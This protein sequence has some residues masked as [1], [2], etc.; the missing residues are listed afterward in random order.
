MTTDRGRGS[1]DWRGAGVAVWIA[2]IV[3]DV[4]WWIFLV[5]AL[6]GQPTPWFG[7]HP[8]LIKGSTGGEG[9]F[10]FSI[11]ST[12]NGG[13]DSLFG[14]IGPGSWQCNV[15]LVALAASVFATLVVAVLRRE[16]GPRVWLWPIGT[17]VGWFAIVV[18][19][20][21]GQWDWDLYYIAMI[22]IALAGIVAREMAAA[23]SRSAAGRVRRGGDPQ[24]VPATDRSVF[25]PRPMWLGW[26]KAIAGVAWW[27]FVVAT[28]IT[29][30]APGFGSA[31]VGWTSYT[32]LGDGGHD[33]FV[34]FGGSPDPSAEWVLWLQWITLAIAL[35]ASLLSAGRLR[36]YGAWVW[37]LPA[38]VLGT[39]ASL[40][41]VFPD[42]YG[43]NVSVTWTIT[44][45]V[46]TIAV[47]EAVTRMI[48][49]L[50]GLKATTAAESG[51]PS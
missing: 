33:S 26:S 10:S 17:V 27:S 19:V 36:S 35:T 39:W 30:D 25:W 51:D 46:M 9:T 40:A 24:A 15:A 37:L 28:L 7:A 13:A 11:A 3:A 43:S 5:A 38:A 32:L 22:G 12:T 23:K 4:A 44:I 48:W 45:V 8:E 41:A 50:A 6:I 29:G 1:G 34:A 47:R 21:S 31:T 14:L 20:R 16:R 49:S 2:S 42:G 18:C